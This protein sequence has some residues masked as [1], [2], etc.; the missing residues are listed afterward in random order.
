[1]DQLGE[2]SINTS[3]FW[4][5]PGYVKFMEQ[6]VEFLVVVVVGAAALLA[7]NLVILRLIVWNRLKDEAHAQEANSR[8][9]ARDLQTVGG[10]R[11][12]VRV[13][14]KFYR[15]CWI[16]NL[17]LVILALIALDLLLLPLFFTS[18]QIAPFVSKWSTMLG[19]TL[20]VGVVCV[21]LFL[22]LGHTDQLIDDH[23]T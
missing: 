8:A 11:G 12:L 3:S 13:G 23:T 20:A 15:L 21:I 1:M 16:R 7:V 22:K 9:P 18:S 14:Y 10:A 6:P 2:L 5:W 19:S 17:I 4:Q